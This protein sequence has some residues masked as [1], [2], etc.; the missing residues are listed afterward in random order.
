MKESIRH[1]LY[2]EIIYTESFWSGKKTLTVNGVDAQ[3]ISKKEYLINEKRAILKGNYYTGACLY[4]DGELIQLTP[5]STW[6]EIILSILPLVFLL[7]WGNS[8]ALCAIFPVIGGAIGGFL[9]GGAFVASLLFM[10]RAK[11]PMSK[12]FIGI[13]VCAV[14]I[15]I[16]FALAI[17]ILSAL[18]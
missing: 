8:P 2:G 5:K 6:Y 15:L 12:I 9:A 17:I 11:S 1:P 13:G 18:Y 3:R 4:I 16:S 10:R 7:T 14:S